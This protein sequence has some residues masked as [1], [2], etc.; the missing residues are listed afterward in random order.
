MRT[1]KQIRPCA[2]MFGW[3]TGVLNCTFGGSNG[4]LGKQPYVSTDCSPQLYLYMSCCSWMQ[5]ANR[6]RWPAAACRS[7]AKQ[8]PCKPC[9]WVGSHLWGTQTS[10]RNNPCSYGVSV[11]PC[12]CTCSCAVLFSSLGHADMPGGGDLDSLLISFCM[13]ADMAYREFVSRAGLQR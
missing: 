8:K 6:T 13:R 10:K 2:S 3:Y 11:G 5:D 9:R 1:S 12:I 4:Y 7:C